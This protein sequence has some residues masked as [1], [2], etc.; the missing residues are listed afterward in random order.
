M[1]SEDVPPLAA[2]L[3]PSMYLRHNA[4][5]PR[6]LPPHHSV[7]LPSP[8]LPIGKDAHVVA[9]KGMEQH[10]FSYVSIHLLLRRKLRILHLGEMRA[11]E[12]QQ[13]PWVSLSLWPKHIPTALTAQRSCVPSP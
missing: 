12:R 7:G 10:L 5:L 6:F 13:G 2:Q 4:L 1:A 3:G 11:E 9:F 8:R